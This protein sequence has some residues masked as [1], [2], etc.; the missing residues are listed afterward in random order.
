MNTKRFFR[1]LGFVF[2]LLLIAG[3]A[4]Q[5]GSSS[6]RFTKDR[7]KVTKAD[8]NQKVHRIAFK[9]VEFNVDMAISGQTEKQKLAQDSV[10]QYLL[11]L[12]QYDVIPPEKC[13]TAWSASLTELNLEGVFDP[14]TGGIDQGKYDAVSKIFMQKLGADSWLYVSFLPGT[15]EQEYAEGQTHTRRKVAAVDLYAN[16]SDNNSNSLWES[17]AMVGTL[18]KRN[19][20]LFIGW[21]SNYTPEQIM[22]EKNIA[23]AVKATF[24]SLR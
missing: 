3:C 14:K 12:G 11:R 18:T 4:M 19:S 24:K 1:N 16:I 20:I 23:K 13:D 6:I 5:Y 7:F 22:T 21:D 17:G 10:M 8:F 15:V 9:G 2:M